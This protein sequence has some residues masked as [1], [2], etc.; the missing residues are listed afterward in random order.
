MKRLLLIF[1]VGTTVSLSTGHQEARAQFIREYPEL[2]FEGGMDRIFDG[3]LAIH[4]KLINDDI[5]DMKKLSRKL[6]VIVKQ[7]NP[8]DM[9]FEFEPHFKRLKKQMIKSCR[10]LMKVKTIEEARIAFRQ[11]SKPMV[12]WASSSRPV[13]IVVIYCPVANATWV[14]LHGEILNPFYGKRLLG[15]GTVVGGGKSVEEALAEEE[16][17]NKALDK[18]VVEEAT[19]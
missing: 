7:L 15:S 8:V 3:Y 13:G 11:L 12:D 16:A 5:S 6:A 9:T 1:L 14:Q 4:D 17:A 10:K 18:G 2:D 19:P